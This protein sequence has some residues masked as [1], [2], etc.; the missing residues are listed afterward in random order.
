MR[1]NGTVGFFFPEGGNSSIHEPDPLFLEVKRALLSENSVCALVREVRSIGEAD[2]CVIRERSSY[3]GHEYPHKLSS[4]PLTGPCLHKIITI[5]TEDGP[6]G[7]LRGLYTSLPRSRF[8]P[9]HHRAVPYRVS[10]PGTPS[11]GM[12]KKYL[13]SWR[14]NVRSNRIRSKLLALFESAPGFRLESTESWFNHDPAERERYAE[15]IRSSG[16]SLC[17]AGWA[18]A[19]VRI[20]E[21]MALGVAPVILAE[22]FVPPSGPD[23]AKAALF[24][25]QKHIGRLPEILEA[26][27]ETATDMGECALAQWREF[28]SPDVIAGYYATS[29]LGLVHSG[30]FERNRD[31]EIRRLNGIALHWKNGWTLPQRIVSKLRRMGSLGNYRPDVSPTCPP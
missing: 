2:F 14:G 4:D 10:D 18:A 15:L 23:W 5:N 20:Y 29:I 25:A 21:S 22:E 9:R 28:F 13:A 31:A 17:P 7:L 3:K 1:I 8:D 24:V 26:A 12:E 27:R 16:F 11:F 30:M 6:S 19:T